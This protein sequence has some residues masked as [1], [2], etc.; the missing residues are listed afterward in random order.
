MIKFWLDGADV[1]ANLACG[2]QDRTH[3]VQGVPV[4][5]GETCGQNL[6][7]G[8]ESGLRK[9]KLVPFQVEDQEACIKLAG[10]LGH[11]RNEGNF[12]PVLGCL[13]DQSAGL[14]AQA[15]AFCP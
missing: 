1:E 8:L 5:L 2:P 6:A 14:G 4:G 9:P 13:D 15:F 11:H 10:T 7:I 12:T 3:R